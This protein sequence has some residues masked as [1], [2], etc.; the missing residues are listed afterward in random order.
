MNLIRSY[1]HEIYSVQVK[2]IA[3]SAK[4][5]KRFIL[6][7]NTRALGHYINKCKYK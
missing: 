1:K 4:D 3:L 7:M 6:G 5:D 2:K